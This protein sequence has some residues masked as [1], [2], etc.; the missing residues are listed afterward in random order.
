MRG[1]QR[2]GEGGNISRTPSSR[3]PLLPAS[4]TVTFPA[5]ERL[6]PCLVPAVYT[7]WWIQARVCERLAYV[8][9][10]KGRGRIGNLEI[11]SPMR[12]LLCHQISQSYCLTR[13]YAV[14]QWNVKFG[15]WNRGH[16]IDRSSFCSMNLVIPCLRA[17]RVNI[18]NANNYFVS[19]V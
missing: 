18:E 17:L 1:W 3:L 9:C 14:D 6:L 13:K 2:A 16:Y 19:I 4:P 7:A 8:R 12:Y 10:M 11:V 5:S 15:T